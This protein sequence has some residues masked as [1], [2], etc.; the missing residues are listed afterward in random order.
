MSALSDL[1]REI[2][3][4]RQCE[5]ARQRTRAV[6]GEG[7]EDA[8]IAFVGEAPGWHEDQQG[9]PQNLS[10]LNEHNKEIARELLGT[11]NKGGENPEL[12]FQVEGADQRGQPPN[13]M[14]VFNICFPFSK[15]IEL[16]NLSK[17]FQIGGGGGG[18]G[19]PNQRSERSSSEKLQGTHPYNFQQN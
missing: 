16:N 1:N 9:R 6:P 17:N 4:C 19:H 11:L 8:A 13:L 5:L 15:L 10:R 18:G 7:A 3:N 2:A 12:V 14:K